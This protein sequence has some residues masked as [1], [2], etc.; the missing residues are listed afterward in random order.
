MSKAKASTVKAFTTNKVYVKWVKKANMWAET[1]F[2]EKGK[3]IIRWF[4]KD[5]NGNEIIK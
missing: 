2:D 4:S 1:R 5:E 3:Q